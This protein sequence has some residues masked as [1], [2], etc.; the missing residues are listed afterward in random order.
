MNNIY[1]QWSCNWN[2]HTY[3]DTHAH[4]HMPV[5]LYMS[6][7]LNYIRIWKYICF[8]IFVGVTHSQNVFF[9]LFVRVCVCFVGGGIYLKQFNT[10]SQH[11]D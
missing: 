2:M 11:E 9:V 10:S 6:K 3:T 4:T 1:L 5:I 8:K 7:E